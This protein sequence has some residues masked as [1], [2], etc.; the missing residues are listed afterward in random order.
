MGYT[1]ETVLNP[2]AKTIAAHE[3]D[4]T[5]HTSLPTLRLAKKWPQ[6]AFDTFVSKDCFLKINRLA[7][8]HV[9]PLPV[10]HTRHLEWLKSLFI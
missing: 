2:A 6:G 1:F 3:T 10:T 8:H 5:S 4:Y 9:L 7:P